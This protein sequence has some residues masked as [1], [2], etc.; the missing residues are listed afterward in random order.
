MIGGLDVSV[1][2][3]R[4]S[5]AAELVGPDVHLLSTDHMGQQSHDKHESRED[6]H[7]LRHVYK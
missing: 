1:T 2:K 3:I 7:Y 5:D 4:A 6:S